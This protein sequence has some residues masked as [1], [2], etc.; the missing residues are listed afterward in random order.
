MEELNENVMVIMDYHSVDGTH[1]N[2]VVTDPIGG[3]LFTKDDAPSGQTAFT[4]TRKGDFKA[5]FTRTETH[6]D[7]ETHREL[8]EKHKV[9]LTWKTGVSATDWESL[10]KK[11]VLD[12]VSMNLR[13]LEAELKEI[14]DG[15]LYMR[16]REEE[17]RDLNEATNARVARYSIISLAMSLSLS[18][19]QLWYMR[20][21]FHKKKLI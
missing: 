12:A 5:C 15:M 17:M 18:V 3:T 21:F 20:N 6:E 14:Y 7:P 11:E 8:L 2:I 9:K 4:T 13:E 10:A 1:V 16:R 19:W